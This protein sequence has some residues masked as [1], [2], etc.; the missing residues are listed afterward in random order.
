MGAIRVL[1]DLRRHELCWENVQGSQDIA[2]NFE[3]AEQADSYHPALTMTPGYCWEGELSEPSYF[4]VCAPKFR[5]RH[6]FSSM[7]NKLAYYKLK[8]MN[9]LPT[10]DSSDKVM[11]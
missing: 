3:Q 10:T 9:R 4:H 6:E 8:Q 5:W 7:S 2:D 1:G 11:C